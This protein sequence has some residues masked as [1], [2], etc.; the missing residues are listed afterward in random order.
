MNLRPAN[1]DDLPRIVEIYNSTIASRQVTADIE[2][3]SVA[4]RMDWFSAHSPDRYPLLVALADNQPDMLG[5]LS[6][7]PFHPRAAY[8]ATS[9]LSIY[10][11]P[12][13]RGQGLGSQLLEHALDQ[14]PSLGFKTLIGLIFGH[15]SPSLALFARFGFSRWGEFPRVAELDG[16]ERDLIIVGRR[17]AP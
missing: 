10:L 14:A 9:E 3:V 2:P 1:L 11:D 13:A 17:L 8:R 7:S 5:W 6:Y 16:I 4:A 12:A 15:N